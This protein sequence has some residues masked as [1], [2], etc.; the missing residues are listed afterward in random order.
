MIKGACLL[1]FLSMLT[2]EIRQELE[3]CILDT[4]PQAFVVDMQLHEGPQATLII[5]IDT[6]QGITMEACT[7]ISR[8]LNEWLD[9][10]DYFPF[11]YRM[12]VSSPGIGF[13]LKLE[14][15]Y[16]NNV[17]RFLGITL[18]D[19]VE[20]KAKLEATHPEGI[21]IRQLHK[22]KGKNKAIKHRMDAETQRLTY[23]EIKQAKIILV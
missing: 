3:Q 16:I 22:P 10:K 21:E 12:E 8:T 2:E 5:K 14:R 6:D 19:G 9:E 20:M 4:N 1:I 13:P 23:A 11:A 15:Q 17:G 7:R 18:Q